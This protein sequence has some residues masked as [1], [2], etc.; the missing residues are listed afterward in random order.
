MIKIIYLFA[1]QKCDKNSDGFIDIDEYLELI[2][3]IGFTD[4]TKEKAV[5]MVAKV[6]SDGDGKI[7]LEG[8]CIHI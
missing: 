2:H 3:N 8:E 4:I 1:L 7:N 5:T 6:D